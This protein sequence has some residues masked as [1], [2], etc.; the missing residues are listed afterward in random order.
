MLTK[1][2]NYVFKQKLFWCC[3][4]ILAVLLPVA[5]S[6]MGYYFSFCQDYYSAIGGIIPHSDAHGYWHGALCYDQ[7]GVLDAWNMRR[8]LNALFL[9]FRLKLVDGN[10]WYAMILQ[11]AICAIPFYFYARLLHSHMGLGSALVGFFFVFVQILQFGATTLSEMLGLTLGLTAFYFLWNGWCERNRL[12]YNAGLIIL[13]IALSA[14]AGP[15]MMILAAFFLVWWSSFTQS[16]WK[17]LALSFLCFGVTFYFMCMLPRLFGDASQ[18]MALSNFSYTLYGLVKGGK[19]WGYYAQDEKIM[20]LIQGKNE[21]EV[22]IILYRESWLAFK[23]NPFGL[24]RGMIVYLFDF[25]RYSIT[26]LNFTH[27]IPRGITRLLALALWVFWAR[28]MYLHRSFM[29]REKTFLLSFFLAIVLSAMVV[30]KDAGIRAFMV[31]I[32][33][34]GALLGLAFAKEQERTKVKGHKIL[35]GLFLFIMA[36]SLGQNLFRRDYSALV[37]LQGED[38]ILI[39]KNLNKMP[40][41][42]ISDE[43]GWKCFQNRNRRIF[44]MYE[45]LGIEMYHLVH[46]GML[47]GWI[48]D[49]RKQSYNYCYGDPKILEAKSPWVAVKIHRQEGTSLAEI[50]AIKELKE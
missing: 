40:F 12:I 33:F 30:F 47:I 43:P 34:W 14:R 26:W 21:A 19:M 44:G 39:S 6:W 4:V 41:L 16:R 17:D 15:Q 10:F 48:Y 24:I 50:V 27:T 29:A 35:F 36:G 49:Y 37:N 23:D 25:L 3:F 20:S 13:T 5:N 45:K 2:L 18:N 28:R 9:A 11:S 8:P 31:A 7:L 46:K 42:K 32:P 38:V 22:S 1:S